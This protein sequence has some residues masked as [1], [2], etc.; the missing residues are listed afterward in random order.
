MEPTVPA[1]SRNA[2]RIGRAPS[3]RERSRGSCCPQ[4]LEYA[5]RRPPVNE[6]AAARRARRDA[7]VAMLRRFRRYFG[8]KHCAACEHPSHAR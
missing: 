7:G 4:R 8:G 2:Y 6:A 5:R 1:L 3:W